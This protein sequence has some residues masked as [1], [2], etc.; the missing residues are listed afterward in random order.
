MPR[1]AII[2][3]RDKTPKSRALFYQPNST[4]PLSLWAKVAETVTGAT[5]TLLH[6]YPDLAITAGWR[7]VNDDTSYR[8]TG[9][10]GLV[11]TCVSEGGNP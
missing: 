10:D 9:V 7:I 1:Q 11:I 5:V 2:I 8:V 3:R 4:E 6:E